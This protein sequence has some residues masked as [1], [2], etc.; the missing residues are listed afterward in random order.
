MAKNDLVVLAIGGNSL[1]MDPQHKTVDDQYHSCEITCGYIAKMLE[2]GYRVVITHGNGPQVGFILRRSELAASE[3]HLVPLDSCVADTQ[4]AIGYH[5]QRAMGNA[6]EGHEK[7]TP[8]ATVVTQVLVDAD[9]P[10][11]KNPTKPIGTFM[12][13]KLAQSRQQ[14]YGWDVVEDSGRGFRRVVASPIPK[15]II[16]LDAIRALVDGGFVVVAAGGGGIPVVNKGGVLD[17]AEAVIDKDLAS[18]M[19]AMELGADLL[20]ISTAVE[21]A[22]VNFGQPD[23]RGLDRVTVAEARQYIEDGYFAPGSMLPKIKAVLEFVEATG[24]DA[25][26]TDPQNM[27]RGLAGETGTRIVAK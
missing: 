5:I 11:F 14:D 24:N 7:R 15:A 4:G 16:E 27:L 23:Q 13:A 9:D 8:V 25:L 20:L 6:M 1:I 19:L 26:I 17:G 18:S 10:A 3:L 22:Y 2:E 21:K 12:D